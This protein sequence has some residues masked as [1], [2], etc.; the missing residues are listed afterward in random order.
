MALKWLKQ[1]RKKLF[2]AAIVE[3][4]ADLALLIWIKISFLFNVFLRE[5]SK[6]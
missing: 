3:I 4:P 6:P 1:I 2:D 5:K